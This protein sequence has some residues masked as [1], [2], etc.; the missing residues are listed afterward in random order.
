ML[1]SLK[2]WGWVNSLTPVDSAGVPDAYTGVP[3]CRPQS[4]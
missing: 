3:H 1:L 2:F 4:R